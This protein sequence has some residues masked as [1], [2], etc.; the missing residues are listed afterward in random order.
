MAQL[1]WLSHFEPSRGITI[2]ANL[3]TPYKETEIHGPNYTRPPPDLIDGEEEYEVEQVL[4]M[5]QKGRGRKT[6]YL[7]KWKGYP[8]SDNSWEPAENL[9]WTS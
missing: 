3:I 9:M 6:Y 5:K 7:I 1:G 4:D 8:T 2:H